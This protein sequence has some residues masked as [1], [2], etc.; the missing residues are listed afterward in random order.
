MPFFLLCHE[1]FF[2]FLEGVG[3][4]LHLFTL[5]VSGILQIEVTLFF[6]RNPKIFT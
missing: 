1:D 3:F 4:I 6:F 5:V 2:L